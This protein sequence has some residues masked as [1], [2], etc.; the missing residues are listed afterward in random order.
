M[1]AKASKN[2]NPTDEQAPSNEP[3][4][5]FLKQMA[6]IEEQRKLIE[7]RV[8]GLKDQ[9]S[10]AVAVSLQQALTIIEKSDLNKLNP[11]G[12]RI[13]NSI[14]SR[15]QGKKAVMS[16][17]SLPRKPQVG[18]VSKEEKAELWFAFFEDK[19][20][21]DTFTNQD[22]YGYCKKQNVVSIGSPAQFFGKLWDTDQIEDT[23]DRVEGTRIIIWRM[24]KQ[25]KRAS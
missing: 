23:G 8:A 21:G 3:A 2:G 13:L 22:L 7:A 15:V 16:K 1:P 14:C 4:A 11:A 25:I 10:V 9:A 17:G 12:T 5:E 6:D 18:K 19:K 20:R 24:K